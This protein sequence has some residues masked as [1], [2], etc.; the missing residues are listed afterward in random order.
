M[1]VQLESRLVTADE[2]LYN[3]AQGRPP[4]TLASFGSSMISAIPPKLPPGMAGPRRVNRKQAQSRKTRE[5][6]RKK[7]WLL[8]VVLALVGIGV[9]LRYPG[10]FPRRVTLGELERATK[11]FAY[12]NYCGTQGDEHRF[13]T[14]A[15]KAFLVSRDELKDLEP[16]LFT[17]PRSEQDVRLQ[18]KV[19]DGKVG[20]PDPQKLADWAR[21]HPDAAAPGA[22]GGGRRDRQGAAG[23]PARHLA[24][25]EGAG[26]LV[27]RR[28]DG[29]GPR[30]AG[31]GA[32]DVARD[33]GPRAEGREVA[34]G[35]GSP[36]APL[37]PGEVDARPDERRDPGPQ[38]QERL[39]RVAGGPA[40]E[41]VPVPLAARGGRAARVE[42]RWPSGTTRSS[43][44][45]G[46][47]SPWTTGRRWWSSRSRSCAIPCRSSSSSSSSPR[48]GTRRPPRRRSRR[49]R[50]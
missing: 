6:F 24:R 9:Y 18:V 31:R 12:I 16:P 35:R 21:S 49:R 13:E 33:R 43:P 11:D 15:G 10:L 14:P 50:S 23:A 2:K 47:R 28:V 40:G 44:C 39:V 30:P 42:R 5:M 29:R 26:P 20:V 8:L 37:R 4:G 32:G 7:T 17:F 45:P 1:A 46:K 41:G 34:V 19:K 22:A 36:P 25:A 27:R 38:F 48:R 3:V